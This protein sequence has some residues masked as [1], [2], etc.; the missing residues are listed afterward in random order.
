MV[1][2]VDPIALGWLTGTGSVGAPAGDGNRDFYIGSESHVDPLHLGALGRTY[3]GTKIAQQ[4]YRLAE[5]A[6]L[7]WIS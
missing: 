2:F 1:G 3:W 6:G 7:T 5:Q 4:V